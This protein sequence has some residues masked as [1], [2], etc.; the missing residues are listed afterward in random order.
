MII[1]PF[2]F[3]SLPKVTRDEVTAQRRLR[4]LAA[5]HAPIA[6]IERALGELVKAPV[7]IRPGRTR[8]AAAGVTVALARGEPVIVVDVETA[9]A[10]EVVAR[11]LAHVP[12]IDGGTTPTATLHGAFAAVLHQALRRAG[13]GPVRVAA[14][15]AQRALVMR[16]TVEVAETLF[17][18][19]VTVPDDVLP[20]A[21]RPRAL[22]FPV[23][24]PL[25]ASSCLALPSQ[26]R[27]LAIGDVFVPP[28]LLARGRLALVAPG[29][30]RGLAVEMTPDHRLVVGK[31]AL[32]AHSW[33]PP[34]SADENATPATIEVALE[35]PVVVRVELG[36]VEM[37]AREW[38]ALAEGDVISLQRKLGE[39]AILRI[40]GAEVARGELVQVDGD[41][42][43]RITSTN[44]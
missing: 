26:L 38:A 33:E 30:E 27:G 9:L 41:Y 25:V 5:A 23:T 24:V 11:A 29:G 22:E 1:A 15:V 31:G 12:G 4:D 43:I 19:S 20:A 34:M 17:D 37:K 3:E 21:A 36:S 7:R 28:G 40:A 16:L 32:E 39:P 10:R 2:P 44:R 13:V 42:G 6:A 14:P 18:A 8:G 35:A